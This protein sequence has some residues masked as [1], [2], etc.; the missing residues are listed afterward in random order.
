MG[1]VEE[2]LVFTKRDNEA[3][4]RP[5]KLS[6]RQAQGRQYIDLTRTTRDYFALGALKGEHRSFEKF[7]SQSSDNIQDLQQKSKKLELENG[8]LRSQIVAT[9]KDVND[10]NEILSTIQIWAEKTDQAIERLETAVGGM[11]K[12]V[13]ELKNR[14]TLQF[15]NLSIGCDVLS[16]SSTPS[17]QSSEFPSPNHSPLLT[18][19]SDSDHMD[20]SL[21]DISWEDSS[22][23]SLSVAGGQS[24]VR[25]TNLTLRQAQRLMAIQIAQ[26]CSSKP[27]QSLSSERT[28]SVRPWRFLTFTQLTCPRQSGTNTD[29]QHIS[30]ALVP[31]AGRPG[32]RTILVCSSGSG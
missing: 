23:N 32:V 21:A 17:D 11:C 9:R 24:A 13:N 28:T 16:L 25:R 12:D 22:K 29:P 26:E 15:P 4:M 18:C 1:Q 3:A 10:V 6:Y 5:F 31:Q 19:G 2:E 20:S 8:I 27:P 7:R 30:T 14:E